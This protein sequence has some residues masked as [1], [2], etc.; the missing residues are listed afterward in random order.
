M[1]HAFCNPIGQLQCLHCA[2]GCSQI[3]QNISDYRHPSTQNRLDW[4][5]HDSTS[6]PRWFYNT[7]SVPNAPTNKLLVVLQ[8]FP[9]LPRFLGMLMSAIYCLFSASARL[10]LTSIKKSLAL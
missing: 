2:T 6:F 1:L 9:Q 5:A 3:A 4:T 7:Q 10:L 8:L